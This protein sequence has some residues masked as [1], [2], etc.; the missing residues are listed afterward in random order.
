MDATPPDPKI[1]VIVP[2]KNAGTQLQPCL[3]ALFNQSI[4]V[5]EVIL[6]DGNSTDDTV[7]IAGQYPLRIISEDYGTVGGAR[8]AG[9]EEAS[10][11]YVAYTDADCRP[12]PDWLEHLSPELRR[13]VAGVGGGVRN[14]GSGIWEESIA[15]ALDTFLGSANSVQDRLIPYKKKVSSISGCNCMYRRL[16]LL[17][18]GGFD[19]GLPVNEDTELNRRIRRL[20][21]L[22]YTPD[23]LV[24]HEQKR[25]LGDF[26]RRMHFFGYGRGRNR[27]W[28]LQVAPPVLGLFVIFTYFSFFEVFL[29]LLLIYFGLIILFDLA[30]FVRTRRPAYLL[31]VPVVYLVEHLSYMLGFWHGLAHSFWRKS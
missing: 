30:I 22:V 26:A 15:L 1:S 24:L 7:E 10:G 31:S 18:V 23:A 27:L 2:A 11:D 12:L 21:D 13:G 9:F 25:G 6:V 8:Q 29:L 3:D 28:D 5:Y 14:I 16:D 20:G 19:V 4:P 17:E